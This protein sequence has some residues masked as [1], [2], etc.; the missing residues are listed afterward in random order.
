M[1]GTVYGDRPETILRK[2]PKNSAKAVNHVLLGTRLE[3][4]TSKTETGWL[5]VDTLGKGASGWVNEDHVRDDP[6]LKV[7]YVDVGQ[8]DGCIVE[9]PQGIMLIDGGPNK[10]FY[11]FLRYR[12]RHLLR[13]GETI[14]INSVVVSHPDADHFAGLT[15]V[16]NDPQFS[17][18][19]IFHNGIIRFDRKKPGGK[20]FDLGTLSTKTIDGEARKVLTDSFSTLA[21]IQVLDQSQLQFT[22]RKFWEAA[23]AAKQQGRL[24]GARRV[25]VRDTTLPGYSGS[26]NNTMKVEVLAPVP[27]SDSGAVQYV[28]FPSPEEPNASP[29]SSHTRNGHSVVLKLTYGE[30]TFLLGGDLNIPAEE[31]LLA[32]YKKKDENPFRVDVAKACHHGSSDFLVDYLKKV[33]PMVNVVSSGDNKSFDHPTADSLGASARHTRGDYPLLFSTELARAYGSKRIHYGL[34]NARSNGNVLTMAQMKEQHNKADVWDSFSV[35]W[36][37]K[38]S[39]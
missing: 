21:Q 12:Y 23:V 37:G 18:G 20:P 13:K 32:H 6:G 38:F 28:G 2:T 3:V 7:F 25:T 30:H 26:Q 22:F 27:T 29:T 35:P 31:H 11:K 36:H 1:T 19:T 34:I 5:W 4:D 14:H 8:G 33:R 15:H 17:F 39:D 24:D 10:N 9:S 16:L